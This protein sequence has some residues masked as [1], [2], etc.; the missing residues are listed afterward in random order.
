MGVH[1]GHRERMRERFFQHGLQTFNEIEALEFLLFYAIP[2]K[3]TNPLAHALL[4]HFGTLD[5]VL[6]ATE[7]QLCEVPGIGLRTA[8]LLM[9]VPQMHRLSEVKKSQRI[10]EI[11]STQ[12][13]I[14][15]LRPYFDGRKDEML[16]FVCLDS[17]CKII[18]AEI[19]SVGVVNRVRFDRRQLVE[20]ALKRKATLVVLAHNHPD[21]DPT[22]SREDDAATSRLLH[23]L[24][25][26]NIE[27][28]DHVILSGEKSYSYRMKGTLSVFRRQPYI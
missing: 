17:T 16:M 23:S 6:N 7:Q 18:S 22:P 10:G 25:D 12:D 21:G 27:L 14:N 19:I 15:Y 9:L 24:L 4:D 2:Q 3:D 26:F 13:A 28:F 5:D 8:A 20:I 11:K 1:D